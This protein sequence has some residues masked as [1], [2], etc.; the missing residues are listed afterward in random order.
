MKLIFNNL[1]NNSFKATEQKKILY[2][3]DK[4]KRQNFVEKIEIKCD[5][6]D[7]KSISILYVDN[8]IG[9]NQETRYKIYIE[10]CSSQV[11][12][13][14]GLGSFIIKKLLELNNATI[15]IEDN[16]IGCEDIGTTQKLVF[17]LEVIN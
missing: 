3:R 13:D 12:K 11:G 4:E 1:F 7:L 14:H 8:G 6:K 17:S 10:K 16:P 2:R 15:S 5:R 9:L